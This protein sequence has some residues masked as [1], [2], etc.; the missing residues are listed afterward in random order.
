MGKGG[1]LQSMTT[2]HPTWPRLGDRTEPYPPE[3][4][5]ILR[6]FIDG[7]VCCLYKG[8]QQIAWLTRAEVEDFSRQLADWLANNPDEPQF[9]AASARARGE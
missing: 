7:K 2:I 9:A 4:L 1:R 3:T 6:A 5:Q 8:P